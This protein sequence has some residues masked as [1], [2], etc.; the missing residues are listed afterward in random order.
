MSFSIH[1]TSVRFV[2]VQTIWEPFL[3]LFFPSPIILDA[4]CMLFFKNKVENKVWSSCEVPRCPPYTL[5]DWPWIY[6]QKLELATQVCNPSR[7]LD[8]EVL[9]KGKN[10]PPDN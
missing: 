6:P 5:S 8:I 1:F 4:L 10:G 3:S 9:R 2:L 7:K